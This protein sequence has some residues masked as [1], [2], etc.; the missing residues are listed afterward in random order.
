MKFLDTYESWDKIFKLVKYDDHFLVWIHGLNSSYKIQL[1]TNE[2]K[3][4]GNFLINFDN[5]D[6]HN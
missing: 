2:L 6:C 1:Q 4:L 5:S 3:E